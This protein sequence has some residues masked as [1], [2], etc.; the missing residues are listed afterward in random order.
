LLTLPPYFQIEQTEGEPLR[1]MP[2]ARDFNTFVS[3]VSR[4]QAFKAGREQ[5]ATSRQNR[6]FAA[7][8]QP[9][10]LHDARLQNVSKE[11][12][13]KLMDNQLRNTG[14]ASEIS[15]LSGLEGPSRNEAIVRLA[16]ESDT[17]QFWQ[18]AL[19]VPRE[20]QERIFGGLLQHAEQIGAIKSQGASREQRQ[21]AVDAAGRRRFIDTGEIVFDEADT[22]GQVTPRDEFE[23]KQT[24]QKRLAGKLSAASEKA[25]IESQDAA[26]ASD[27]AVSELLSI[28]TEFDNLP[29]DTAAG[30]RG[31][32]REFLV[33]FL[34]TEDDLTAL[35]RR[36]NQ[37]KNN[38]VMQNLPPGV[39]SDKD[40]EI[41]MSGFLNDTA[42]PTTAAS[43]LRG[44]AKIETI[45]GEFNAFKADW[46]SENGNTRGMFKAWKD[47]LSDENPSLETLSIEDLD[48]L[49]IE[50][51]QK[52][53]EANQ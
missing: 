49:S 11:Q 17:P 32:A 8:E 28:A 37:V 29:T 39:A 36:Y 34:G 45:N 6:E 48:A 22:S 2:S 47:Q 1:L 15:S 40:I 27:T 12:Q 51:L 7:Q 30:A 43:F 18:R 3:P 24:E 9:H 53:K 21:T 5:I 44:L 38:Q 19:E 4:S 25:L 10:R 33:G 23:F 31:R 52:L 42:N 35:R 46:I 13:I 20:E 41:A 16:Q 26:Q 50:Q 14:L